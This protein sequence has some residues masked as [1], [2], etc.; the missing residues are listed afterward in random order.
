ML[1]GLIGLT[2]LAGLALYPIGMRKLTR[3]YPN[4]VVE[5]VN[6]PTGAD[7]VARGKHIAIIWAC[8]KCHGEDLSGALITDDPISGDLQV[9]LFRAFRDSVFRSTRP[10]IVRAPR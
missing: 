3:T 4:I 1:G 5:T 2:L 8:T 7:A 6:I 9:R 10:Q